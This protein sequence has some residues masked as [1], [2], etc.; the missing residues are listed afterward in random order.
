MLDCFHVPTPVL[1]SVGHLSVLC[2]P[3]ALDDLEH[4]WG[5]RKGTRI[6]GEK[7][8]NFQLKNILPDPQTTNTNNPKSQGPTGEESSLAFC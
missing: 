6:N 4:S 2:H 8:Y 3:D 7:Q 5:L 1:C